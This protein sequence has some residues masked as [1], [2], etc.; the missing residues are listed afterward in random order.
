MGLVAGNGVVLKVATQAQPVGEMLA[1]LVGA[2]DLPKGL[3]SL[4]HMA[5][6]AAGKAF[7]ESGIAKL[8]FT[9]SVAVG[10][11]L[12]RLASARLLPLSLEL[13]GN[14][15]MIVLP[16]ACLPRAASGAIWAGFS[17]AGQSC[18]GVQRIL[19]HSSVYDELKRLL[20]EGIRELRMGASGGPDVE[21]G[22]LATEAQRRIVEEQ[23]A[24]A[25]AK[26]ASIAISHPAELPKGNF[27]RCV[28]LENVSSDMRVMREECFGPL[29]TLEPYE[30]IG[31]AI[32][33]ANDS[34]LGLTASVWTRRGRL[35]QAGA[36]RL[37]AGC[38]TLN[39][40]LMSHG[41]AE[42]PWGGYKLSGLGRTHGA[43]GLEEMTQ[44]K[45]VVRDHYPSIAKNLF[46]HP[47]SADLLKGLKG[48][49]RLLYGKP[50]DGS[51]LAL[52]G[53]F[54]GRMKAKDR[55]RKR[56]S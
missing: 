38:V 13:G 44:P 49:L 34:E 29:I 30:E 24:D 7:V 14:D 1:S 2:A 53:L 26:G 27:H 25:L 40:H 21:I 3:F 23:L 6:S 8:F 19:A 33:K 11:E 9:G 56:P 41:M 20:V 47:Y 39:D 43:L 37:E 4:V 50:S 55:A 5:G 17:N 31:E 51:F 45:V 28:L 18:G 54:L 15:P 35:A 12:M 16:D 32:A 10:K 22:A 52:V 46:W 48:A 36:E 42:T